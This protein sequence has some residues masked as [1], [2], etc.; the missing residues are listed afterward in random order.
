MESPV[1]V[2]E[3]S[4][5]TKWH[6]S[7]NATTFGSP[8]K[9]MAA[10][11][12]GL[13]MEEHGLHI[14]QADLV[15]N[16]SGSAPPSMEGSFAA[17]RNLLIE[18]NFSVNFSLDDLRN[19]MGNFESDEQMRSNPAYLAYYFSNM[20]VNVRLPPP[21]ISK[22]NRHLLHHIRSFRNNWKL[23]S[24]DDSGNGF[25]HLSQGSLSTHKEVTEE[26]SSPKQALE[27]IAKNG[28]AAMLGM[29]RVSSA[30]RHKSLV[31]LIQV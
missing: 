12:L 17:I 18:Q 22:E 16:R 28:A 4:R 7:G 29:N 9:G 6:S 26:E 10:E 5:G 31:D 24:T 2:V 15:P 21:I 19:T 3:S 25:L 20:N 11:E 27:D 1:R 8:V 14:H 30:S 23:T 13:F